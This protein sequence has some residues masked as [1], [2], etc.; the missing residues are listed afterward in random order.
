MKICMLLF[1][2]IVPIQASHQNSQIV[3]HIFLPHIEVIQYTSSLLITSGKKKLVIRSIQNPH[4]FA[5]FERGS[6]GFI[7][8]HRALRFE[9]DLPRCY[10]EKRRELALISSYAQ[11]QKDQIAKSLVNQMS[12]Q[13]HSLFQM[14]L[15]D[16]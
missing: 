10:E 6:D 5:S 8:C 4:Y 13:Q 9:N 16:L 15:D 7:S 12:P 1:F 2:L 14:M 3:R 11:E